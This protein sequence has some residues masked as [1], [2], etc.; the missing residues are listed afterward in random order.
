MPEAAWNESCDPGRAANATNC[1]FG[2]AIFSMLAGAGGKSVVYGKPGWQ[3]GPGVPADGARDLPDV[4][5]AAASVHDEVVC[6]GIAGDPCHTNAQLQT[7][8]LTL[9]GGTSVATSAMAGILALVEQ[10]NGA[11]QGQANYVLYGLAR[12]PGNRCPSSAE[13]K[14]PAANS[15]VFYDITSGSNSLPCTGGSSG[16][17]SSQAGVNGI[18]QGEVAGPGFDLVTGLGS[19][20]AGNL[21]AA[22]KGVSATAQVTSG[23]FSITVNPISFATGSPGITTVTITPS[24]GFTGAVAL[25][26]ATGGTMVPAG[27]TCSFG[28][29]SVM[30]S[31]GPATTSLNL[32]LASSS[33]AGVKTARRGDA[34]GMLNEAVFAGALLLL[35]LL[36]L[37]EGERRGRNFIWGC[38]FVLG[39]LSTISACGGGGGSGGPVSTTT[40]ISSSNLHVGVGTPVTFTVTVKPNGNAT[41]TGPVQLFDNGQA[42]GGPT[43]VTAGIASF[44]AAT[45]PAGVN[46]VTAQ[47]LGDAN[48]L[49]STSSPVTQLIAGTVALQ[50]TGTSGGSSET[51]DAILTLQ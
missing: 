2:N 39:V 29:S 43:N 9:V 34:Y 14:P 19:V 45:L 38:G 7:L 46:T 13:S 42:L 20:N 11:F 36:G 40:T 37:N 6:T 16:C 10:K 23:L 35:G 12:T 48:T 22:W 17:L 51:A 32:T 15:C 8:D 33:A 49:G 44:L 21:A 24:G 28:S 3:A 1:K 41:P 25:T 47:Y 26:C 30:V 27:Y 18:L 31:G 4:A 50:I 5:L